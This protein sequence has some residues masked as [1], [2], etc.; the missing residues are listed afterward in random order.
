MLIQDISINKGG[1]SEN[2]SDLSLGRRPPSKSD[3][4][5]E[6]PPLFIEI[7]RCEIQEE[8]RGSLKKRNDYH[9]REAGPSNILR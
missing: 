3:E 2:S 7:Q 9:G 5:D 6:A 8:E 4:K 1:G